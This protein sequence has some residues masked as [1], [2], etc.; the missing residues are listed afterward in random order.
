MS[1]LLVV[2]NNQK[3]LA[4]LKSFHCLAN[5]SIIFLMALS[6]IVSWL[7]SMFALI[8]DVATCEKNIFI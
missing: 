7:V 8:V 6:F 4:R 1:L 5:S 3:K 2:F